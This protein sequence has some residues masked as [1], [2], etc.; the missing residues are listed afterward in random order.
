M[1]RL[2]HEG[3]GARKQQR[4]L[5]RLKPGATRPGTALGRTVDDGLELVD[6][7]QRV[8][9][10]G[11]DHVVAGACAVDRI[12][13]PRVSDEPGPLP[14]RSPPDLVGDTTVPHNA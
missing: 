7:N 4:S 8:V 2:E 12:G 6:V 10:G 3:M 1:S 14:A 11:C 13:T 9:G 5:R